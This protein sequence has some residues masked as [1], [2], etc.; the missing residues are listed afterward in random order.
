M[1]VSVSVVREQ[2]PI[3]GVIVLHCVLSVSALQF[4]LTVIAALLHLLLS[5]SREHFTA[6]QVVSSVIALQLKVV[7]LH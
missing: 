6:L 5:L 4:S 3:S 7:P 1:V 2:S